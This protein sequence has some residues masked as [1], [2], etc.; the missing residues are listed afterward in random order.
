MSGDPFESYCE[1]STK[2]PITI[3]SE[4]YIE[5]KNRVLLHEQHQVRFEM[6]ARKWVGTYTTGAST[7]FGQYAVNLRFPRL[8]LRQRIRWY[9]R[10]WLGFSS[11]HSCFG[12]FFFCISRKAYDYLK[13]YYIA[14][15]KHFLQF[16]IRDVS[17]RQIKLK[18]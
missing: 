6:E 11:D 12:R 1:T 10:R 13:L 4:P 16:R 5:K 9:L 2:Q 18:D 14:R 15:Y 17:P 8:L 7:F 3:V